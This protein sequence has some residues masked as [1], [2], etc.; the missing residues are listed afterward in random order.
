MTRVNLFREIKMKKNYAILALLLILALT[1]TISKNAIAETTWNL[2]I[3]DRTGQQTIQTY[4]QVTQLPSITEEA[5]LSCYGSPVAYGQWT[6]I[7]L[8]DLLNLVSA[9]TAGGSV[10]FIAQDGYRISIPMELAMK[11]D[12]ILAYMLDSASL[13]ETYRLVVPEAN[14]N[15]W[16][17]Q[18]TS[19]TVSDAAAPNVL[20]RSASLVDVTRDFSQNTPQK[21]QSTPQSSSIT[22]KPIPPTP[23][24]SITAKP[25]PTASPTNDNSSYD[26]QIITQPALDSDIIYGLIA[27]IIAL[28]AVS[29]LVVL[30]LKRQKKAV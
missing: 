21:A 17:A 22:P 6:G 4:N 14:G 23:M 16:I 26:P 3:T 12:V 11:S 9:D 25:T 28:T 24:P 7:K 2:T 29:G 30:R 19:I 1:V 8:S 27:G 10:D 20:G 13:Y 15:V 5:A 18:V